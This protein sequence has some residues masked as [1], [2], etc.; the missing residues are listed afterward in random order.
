MA[1]KPVNIYNVTGTI[2]IDG[3]AVYYS[4]TVQAANATEAADKAKAAEPTLSVTNIN[5]A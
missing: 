4:V 5:K 3:K 2:P 1:D